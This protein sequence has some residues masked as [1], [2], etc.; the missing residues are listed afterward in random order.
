MRRDCLFHE[1]YSENHRFTK[2]YWIMYVALTHGEPIV[3]EFDF[4][5][6]GVAI[7]ART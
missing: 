2:P 3:L 7:T 6:V 4:V 5:F 1:L